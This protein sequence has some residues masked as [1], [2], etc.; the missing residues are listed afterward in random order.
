MGTIIITGNKGNG[1]GGLPPQ[2]KIDVVAEGDYT[3]ATSKLPKS[4]RTGFAGG[5]RTGK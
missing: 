4:Q 3:G 2:Q 5:N 1:G